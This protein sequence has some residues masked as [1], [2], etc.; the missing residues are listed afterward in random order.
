VYAAVRSR[1][2]A[3]WA[4]LE[5]TVPLAFESVGY[6][7]DPAGTAFLIVEVQWSGGEPASIGSPGNNLVRRYGSIWFHAF[8]PV[9]TSVDRALEIVQHAA[10]IFENQSFG[11]V[12][13]TAMEPGAGE[14]GS[15][16]GL[17]YGQSVQIP[18]FHDE[19]A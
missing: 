12:I 7:R 13:C 9:G 19:A 3:S 15:D 6:Q 2:V 4:A 18:F 1:I 10:S 5:P 11:G 17:Y 16:D 14:S 8:I